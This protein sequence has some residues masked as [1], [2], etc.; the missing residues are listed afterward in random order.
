MNE[1]LKRD[2]DNETC[3]TLLGVSLC[4]GLPAGRIRQMVRLGLISPISE[5]PFLF[6][7]ETPGRVAKIERLR[8]HLNLNLSAAGLV[9]DLVDRLESLQDEVDRLHREIS[10]SGFLDIR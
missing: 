1:L 8:N 10:S 3:L 5:S 2:E 4:T 6:S 9:V 7:L